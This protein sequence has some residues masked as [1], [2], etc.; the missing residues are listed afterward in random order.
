MVGTTN[1]AGPR[2]SCSHT[3]L[4]DD[5]QLRVLKQEPRDSPVWHPHL[6]QLVHQAVHGPDEANADDMREL[7]V[8]FVWDDD[9]LR[10]VASVVIMPRC[11][12]GSVRAA[13]EVVPPARHRTAEPV[14]H[15]PRSGPTRLNPCMRGVSWAPGIAAG[16]LRL[17]QTNLSLRLDEF[18]RM[19]RRRLPLGRTPV[20]GWLKYP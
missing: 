1:H 10:C 17:P 7:S 14:P 13:P 5:N 2:R 11:D 6:E 12:P 15:G 20:V 8:Q 4:V 19:L 3:S 9:R 18:S 16:N